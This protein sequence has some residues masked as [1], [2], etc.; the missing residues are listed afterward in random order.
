MSN[1]K[2]CVLIAGVGGSTPGTELIKSFEMANT[3]YKIVATDMYK[4]SVGLFS[5]PYRYVIPSSSSSN[6]IDSLLKICKKENVE[7]LTTGS[8]AELEVVAKN[9]KLF[10]E[11]NI[12]LLLNPL[13]V[14]QLCNDK[15]EL[16]KLLSSQNISCPKSFLFENNDDLKKVEKFPVIIKPR[17][18]SGSRNVFVVQDKEEFLFFGNYLKKYGLMPLVQEYIDA[19]S[20]EYTVGILYADKGKLSC[21]IAMRRMLSHGF[22]FG[23]IIE[24]T[25]T[26]KEYMISSPVSEGVFDEFTDVRETCE[27]IAKLLDVNGPINIQCRKIGSDVSIFEI[28]PRFSASLT[29]RTMVGFNEPD[30]YSRYLLFNELPEKTNYNFGYV[31][32]DLVE[33]YIS[34]SDV[35]SVPSL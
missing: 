16:T 24:N 5:T 35:E 15:F 9:S 2:I 14:I 23:Q 6:Y 17:F 34:F 8:A 28:N 11:N 3:D 22:S 25:S 26:K 1:S 31:L 20:E 21:S 33:K 13:N 30:I 4:N 27:K 7:L 10:E 19:A 12:K 29:T 32:R 18:G